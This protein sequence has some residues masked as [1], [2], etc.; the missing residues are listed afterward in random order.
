[1]TI[2]TGVSWTL[3]T[4]TQ[5]KT[6]SC[7]SPQGELLSMAFSLIWLPE[8]L[9]EVGLKV[10]EQTGWRTRGH[11][12]VGSIKGVICHHTAG[13]RTGNMPSLGVV[14]NGRPGLSG[15][16]AQL[17]LGRD[18]TWFVIAAGRASHAGKGEW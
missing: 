10:A 11:G 18:G 4:A 3:A 9:E 5:L 14:T 1:M 7:R 2:P 16:L 8:V 12:D 6:K 13:A 15:P 17:G